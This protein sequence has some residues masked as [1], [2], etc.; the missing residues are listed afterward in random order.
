MDER[1]MELGREVS[2]SIEDV[3]FAYAC[4]S[5]NEASMLYCAESPVNKLF[6]NNYDKL[7]DI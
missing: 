5:A 1:D 4:E 2:K 3:P 6:A 7:T